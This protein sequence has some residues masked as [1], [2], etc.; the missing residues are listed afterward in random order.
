MGLSGISPL[1][2]LLI[3]GIVVL[4]FGTKRLRSLGR[5]AGEA[6]KGFRE[7]MDPQDKDDK[8]E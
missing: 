5:D 7:G 1:S 3:L 8:P 4:I 2:L 6:V